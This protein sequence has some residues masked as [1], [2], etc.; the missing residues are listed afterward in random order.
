MNYR[1]ILYQKLLNSLR[2]FMNLRACGC[3]IVT[4]LMVSKSTLSIQNH[5]EYTISGVKV[6]LVT[7][8]ITKLKVDAIVNAANAS[9]EG[10]SGVDGAIHGAA[11]PQLRQY[12]I[13]HF[14]EKT[15]GNKDRCEVGDVK[16]S[17]SFE[18]NK[19]GIRYIIHTNGPQG[20]TEKRKEL[21]ESC[22]TNAINAAHRHEDL[23]TIAQSVK[24]T[25]QSGNIFSI[26]LPA[27]SVG[28]FGYP[29]DEATKVAVSGTLKTIEDLKTNN[30]I[31]DLYFVIYDNKDPINQEKLFTLYETELD[32]RAKNTKNT[33]TRTKP[34][35]SCDNPDTNQASKGFFA[36]IKNKFVNFWTPA[37]APKIGNTKLSEA[38]QA[39]QDAQRKINLWYLPRV[40]IVGALSACA[41]YLIGRK[42]NQPFKL[43]IITGTIGVM[44][45]WLYLT[46]NP[47]IK[48]LRFQQSRLEFCR[49]CM[50]NVDPEL[51][52]TSLINAYEPVLENLLKTE[53]DKVAPE[54]TKAIEQ[55]SQDSRTEIAQIHENLILAR[56]NYYIECMKTYLTSKDTKLE[57]PTVHYRQKV[58]ELEKNALDPETAK[59]IYNPKDL[60]DAAQTLV[61]KYPSLNVAFQKVPLNAAMIS[62]RNMIE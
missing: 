21:L 60:F 46:Y 47:N 22:Y 2:I 39:H 7:Q 51:N 44:A 48:R 29:A 42:I 59:K 52:P 41:G 5:I 10:G 28:I 6:H 56:K 35:F 40:G 16:T 12:N 20:S 27:I 37:P 15:V 3:I 4:L 11:G 14:S 13:D 55:K 31:K 57:T 32:A 8:D 36:S 61:G 18:L 30:M 17:P 53:K 1:K 58:E 34:S 49:S 62:L 26:A 43:P 33:I 54:I 50:G 9:L 38:C 24:A 25:D 19:V 45:T 23:K